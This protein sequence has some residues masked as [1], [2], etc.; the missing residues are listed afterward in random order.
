MRMMAGNEESS[1]VRITEDRSEE[2]PQVRSQDRP[3]DD[4]ARIL[5]LIAISILRLC[6]RFRIQF[7]IRI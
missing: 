5:F 6:L 1:W 3:E 2:G 7:Q 4:L